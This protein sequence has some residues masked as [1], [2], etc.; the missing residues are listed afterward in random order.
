MTEQAHQIG[1]DAAL[2][3]VVTEPDTAT[4]RSDAPAVLLLN[5]GLLISP[6]TRM[7]IGSTRGP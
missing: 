3:G 2:V 6:T 1:P 4:R 7:W 5:A